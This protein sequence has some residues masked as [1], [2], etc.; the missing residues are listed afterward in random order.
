LYAPVDDKLTL[1]IDKIELW[2]IVLNLCGLNTPIIGDFI[3]PG[4]SH[5]MLFL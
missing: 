2:T 5:H 1:I 4:T 3:S